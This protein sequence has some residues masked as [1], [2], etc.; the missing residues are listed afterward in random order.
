MILQ[1]KTVSGIFE[2][3]LD[4]APLDSLYIHE[5]IVERNLDFLLKSLKSSG[6]QRDPIIVDSS[7]GVILDGMHRFSA[8]Q[9]LGLK[10]IAVAK[11]DYFDPQIFLRRWFRLFPQKSLPSNF[12]SRVQK[13][14][15]LY[16]F[17]IDKRALH[18]KD[19]N[20]SLLPDKK[21][22]KIWVKQDGILEIS[23]DLKGIPL[24][25]RFNLLKRLEE[26]ISSFLKSPPLYQAE[27]QALGSLKTEGHKIVLGTPHIDKNDVV[28]VAREGKVFP[29][30]TT[31][32]IIP[33]RPLFLNVPLRLLKGD[34]LGK[35]LEEKKMI[36][37]KLLECKTLIQVRGKLEIDRLYEENVLFVFV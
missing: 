25:E 9:K 11:V 3:E 4:I 18:P 14:L 20:E 29:P 21:T 33:A 27:N 8:I 12:I 31:R 30:K 34:G 22:V 2:V 36:L 32:H 28:R 24:T 10:Y 6:F 5:E 35:G 1:F 16:D 7:S 13:I 19:L 26:D 17:P 23:L 37:D 15:Q